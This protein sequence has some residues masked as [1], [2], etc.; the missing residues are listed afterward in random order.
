MCS[1]LKMK[2]TKSTAENDDPEISVETEREI[3]CPGWLGIS[4]ILAGGIL[5]L[6]GL[7]K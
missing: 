1:G 2:I 5:Y 4:F 6:A 3:S 7:R